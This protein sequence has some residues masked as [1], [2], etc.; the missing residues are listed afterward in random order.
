[1]SETLNWKEHLRENPVFGILE[2]EDIDELLRP[3]LSGEQRFNDK[4]VILREGGSGT[5]LYVIGKGQVRV[6]AH[7][8]DGSPITLARLSE[9][10][11]FGEMSFFDKKPRS[12]SVIVDDEGG[13]IVREIMG[14]NFHDFLIAH[15]R[16][17]FK[18]TLILSDRLRRVT[19]G[20]I[21]MQYRALAEKFELLNVK[22]EAQLETIN[23][24]LKTTTA[25][26]DATDNR[27]KEI[28]ERAESVVGS[29]RQNQSWLKALLAGVSVFAAVSG[30]TIGY[31]AYN[32]YEEVET[33][34]ANAQVN[35][36]KTKESAETIQALSKSMVVQNELF[37]RYFGL[38][39]LQQV[40][41]E[42]VINM[43]M[44]DDG[45]I[46]NAKKQRALDWLGTILGESDEDLFKATLEKLFTEALTNG[47]GRSNL[48]AI[49][50][51]TVS[52]IPDRRK[53]LVYYLLLTSFYLD[54]L[55]ESNQ[56]KETLTD[57][58]DAIESY[59][60]L[61][62]ET[63]REVFKDIVGPQNVEEFMYARFYAQSYAKL[64]NSSAQDSASLEAINI[65]ARTKA[66]S[67]VAVLTEAWKSL[68]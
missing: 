49:I 23:N 45:G 11:V 44:T 29:V 63:F 59:K 39:M 25:L 53:I 2:P 36:D 41:D 35:I 37:P 4:D 60:N 64:D 6:D 68:P 16:L 51:G 54:G 5:S 61:S 21:N 20:A 14:E 50:H 22:N 48:R 57:L 15:P 12:A 67:N 55:A 58:N 7:A 13:C 62:G 31:Y 46:D 42:D 65:E 47:N 8:P 10:D 33:S 3:E 19:E 52:Q 26:F 34:I 32:K 24:A 18:L 27:V 30:T 1:M 17:E 9:G 28:S 40:L 38:I 56:Y 66:R 43:H